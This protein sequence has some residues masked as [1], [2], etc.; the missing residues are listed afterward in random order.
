ML[1]FMSELSILLYLFMFVFRPVPHYFDYYSSEIMIEIR[2][3]DPFCF[4]LLS[5]YHVGY[6]GP[7]MVQTNLV[8]LKY[9]GRKKSLEF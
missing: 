1:G 7:L 6:S 4:V 8:F 5:Q 3:G 2:Y 9:F